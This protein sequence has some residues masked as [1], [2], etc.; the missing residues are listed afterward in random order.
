MG[1]EV[2]EL[3]LVQHNNAVSCAFMPAMEMTQ[4]V[5]RYDAVL[6]F[7]RRIMKDGKDYGKV[8]GTDK[9]TLLKPG[10]EKLCSF[11][12]L[13]PR[14]EAVGIVEDWAGLPEHGN[15]PLFY[16]RYRCQLWRGDFLIAESE[17]SCSSRESK[18]RYRWVAE[19][20]IPTGVDKNALRS[21][22]GRRTLTEMTFA[23]EK[24]ET[25]GAYGKPS[26]YWAAFENAIHDGTA[27]KVKKA[28]K[29]GERDAWQITVGERQ[30]R[31]PNPDI[32]DQVNTIQK[33]AQ[34]RS[35][36]ATTLIAC[37]ASEYYT[38]DLEDLETEGPAMPPVYVAEPP[39]DDPPAPKRT[40]EAQMYIDMATDGKAVANILRELKALLIEKSGSDL[41]F[42]AALKTHGIDNEQDYKTKMTLPRAHDIIADLVGRILFYGGMK[43][44]ETANA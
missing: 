6:D 42:G 43:V 9:A 23:V 21:K 25:T 44:M 18:Y 40:P 4:A 24:R 22:D 8:P 26:E 7:T 39:L 29:S 1:A 27:K 35:L 37:N 10:A 17:G 15:E 31:V 19:S 34:K 14:F 32:A 11:F 3:E 41:E 5:N 33:M 30:Y 36:I 20:E 13:T 12:G 16:Y 28:T 2:R 38:Q